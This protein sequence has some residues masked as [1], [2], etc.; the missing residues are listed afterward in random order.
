MEHILFS[1]TATGREEIWTLLRNLWEST[2]VRRPDPSWGSIAG[3]ACMAFWTESKRHNIIAE[4]RW[5]TLA[6]ESAHLIWKLHCE[7]VIANEGAEFSMQE[8]ASRWFAPLDR[9]I[10]LERRIVALSPVKCRT[11]LAGVLELVWAPIL[12]SSDL[13]PNWVVN[14]GVLVGIKRG[15]C[16]SLYADEPPDDL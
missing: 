13:P 3:A 11:K 7:Q 2:G 15:R 10:S 9:C 16:G 12:D 4:K 14:S 5:W 8:V 6:V 1:C